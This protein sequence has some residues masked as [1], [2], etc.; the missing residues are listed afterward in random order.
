VGKGPALPLTS[1]TLTKAEITT[2]ERRP[3]ELIVPMLRRLTG[4]AG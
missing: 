1:G 4:I 2:R 3:I